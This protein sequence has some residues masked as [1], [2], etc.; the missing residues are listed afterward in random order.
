MTEEFVPRHLPMRH[1]KFEE[2]DK[3]FDRKSIFFNSCVAFYTVSEEVGE[4]YSK[5]AE[6][7]REW[8]VV[9]GKERVE[10]LTEDDL[11]GA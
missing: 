3:I 4:S 9:T 6:Q 7:M 11:V 10:Q 1:A 8:E 2:E 5:S